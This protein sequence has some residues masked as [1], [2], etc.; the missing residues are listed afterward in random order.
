MN[1]GKAIQRVQ[2]LY[3]RGVQSKNTR[4]SSRHIYSAICSGR[5]TLISQQYNK[6]QKI[7][8]W[9]YQPLPCVEM[10]T[11][12][13]HECVGAPPSGCTVLRG[14]HKMP[15]PITGIDKHLIQSVSSIDGTTESYDE[16][17]LATS[18]YAEGDKFTSNKPQFY[19]H[20]GYPFITVKKMVK[21][22]MIVG[23]FNDPV[24][25]N[26]FPT[27]CDCE[28]CLCNEIT[29]MDF[30]IDS[31]LETALFQLASNELIAQFKQSKED[32]SA[33]TVDDTNTGML[34]QNQGG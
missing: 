9:A 13:A 3:S 11:A 12:K 23:V 26:L 34:H 6:G 31:N 19:I 5:S 30:P 25:A 8:Q 15:Q 16:T 22:I 32:R 17:T 21:A 7:G 29:E 2:S 24:E 28:D 27:L 14:K 33:N 20:N 1:L 10:I 18:K 4:L